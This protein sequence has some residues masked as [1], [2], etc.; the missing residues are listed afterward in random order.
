MS[1][2][3][4]FQLIYNCWK[5]HSTE[6]LHIYPCDSHIDNMLIFDSKFYVCKFERH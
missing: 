6:A 5:H 3:G 1:N 2:R 4:I